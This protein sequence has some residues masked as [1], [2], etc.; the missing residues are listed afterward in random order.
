LLFIFCFLRNVFD[1]LHYIIKLY[2]HK[3]FN[4]II[5]LYCIYS[6]VIIHQNYKRLRTAVIEVWE[7]ITNAE[8]KNVIKQML[9]RCQ[10]M[11]NANGMYI[12]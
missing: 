3:I 7:L 2:V 10:I 11:I 1:F 4:R 6:S 8:I 9:K 5:A 12:K